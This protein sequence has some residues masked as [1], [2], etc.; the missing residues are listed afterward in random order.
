MLKHFHTFQ[1][2][3]FQVVYANTFTGLEYNIKTVII[4]Q[5]YISS[6]LLIEDINRHIINFKATMRF[7]WKGFLLLVSTAVYTAT[8][9]PPDP[10]LNTI[11]HIDYAGNATLGKYFYHI[12]I[13][14]L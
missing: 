5:F 6:I 13:L 7:T 12:H 9:A 3:Y 2:I 14:S 8:A 10:Q 11:L 1:K 4:F